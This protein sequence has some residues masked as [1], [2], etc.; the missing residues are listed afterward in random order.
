MQAEQLFGN[1]LLIIYF[2]TLGINGIRC[3]FTVLNMLLPEPL[4]GDKITGHFGKKTLV[5]AA[6]NSG[7]DATVVALASKHKDSKSF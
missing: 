4:E 7:I 5:T 1:I 6:V 3:A 2:L